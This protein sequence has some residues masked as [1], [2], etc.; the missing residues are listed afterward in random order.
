MKWLKRFLVLVIAVGLVGVGGAWLMGRGNEG[1]ASYRTAKVTRGDVLSTI[2][3]S[4]VVQAEEV[5]DVGA[6]V[7]GEIAEFGLDAD[8]QPVNHKSRVK[9]GMV[10][11]KIDDALQRSA[12]E[13]AQA[14][15]MAAEA[16][17]KRAEADL[18]QAI[19]KKNQAE[20]DWDR[21]QKLGPSDA[22]AQVTYDNYR[23]VYETSV[24]AVAVADA[25]IA[26]ANGNVAQAKAE[27][28]RAERDLAYTTIASPI[29]GQIIERRVNIGQTVVSSM[30]APSLF[31]L[32][33]DLTKL[34]VWVSVNEADIERIRPGQPVTFTVNSIPDRT[35]KGEVKLVRPKAEMTQNV[36][37]YLVEVTTDNSD[38]SLIPYLSADVKFE[39]A[40]AEDVLTV[41]N[42]ALRY[43][44]DDDRIAPDAREAEA[45][46]EEGGAVAGGGDS[47]D[48][49]RSPRADGARRRRG[50]A[51]ASS[52]RPTAKPQYRRATLW[53]RDG[54]FLRPIKVEAGVTDS[55]IT[56]VRGEG[57]SEDMEVITGEVFSEAAAAGSTNPFGP[58]QWGRRGSS[59]GG[60]RGRGG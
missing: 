5:V 32:A 7:N 25:S 34:Q 30:N 35:F 46:S 39:V 56:E 33:K 57:L 14:Q 40:R 52:T 60:G 41:P 31:L 36:V 10:L 48:S 21:A 42:A 4:G 22:L 23:A 50:D 24:A 9:K 37:T 17:V 2:S 38:Y 16:G 55:V 13:V 18:Q 19:A 11:A 49:G 29:D 1:P 54:T 59:G 26:Q 6:R 3:S 27:L 15:V 20:R 51:P 45:S 58:P 12:V 53:V 47:A 28:F 44:P 8:G 43:S